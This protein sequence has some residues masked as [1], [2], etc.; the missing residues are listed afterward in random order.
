MNGD[1]RTSKKPVSGVSV[2]RLQ[3]PVASQK[4][5]T[6]SNKIANAQMGYMPAKWL[7]SIIFKIQRAEYIFW[8]E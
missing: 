4:H 6:L 3:K 2:P 5:T 1:G 7:K 8:N